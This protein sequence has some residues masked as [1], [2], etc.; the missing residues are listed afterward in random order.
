MQVIQANGIGIR[1][2]QDGTL[3]GAPVLLLHPL[4]LDLRVWDDLVSHLPPDLR[5]IR[6]DLR[7]HGGSDVPEGA[8]GMQSYVHDTAG[9]L[10]AL[11]VQGA[12]VV[13]LGMG[14]LVAQGLAAERPDL[15]RALVLACTAARIGNEAI[16]ANRAEAARNLGMAALADEAITRWLPARFRTTRPEVAALWRERLLQTPPEGHAGACAAIGGTDLL[17]STSRLRLPAM[18]VA[19]AMDAAV[20]ADMVRETA[21]LIPGAEFHVLPGVGHL[22]PVE[23]PEAFAA[24]L[25]P[26]LAKHAP[27]PDLGGAQDPPRIL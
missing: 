8:Q 3:D 11:D 18:A 17:T 26:F 13:G 19:G 23:A 10:D 7:G 1:H 6:C 9:L 15:V 25:D 14:G 21:D 2:V 16:W 20:P 4:G 24:L 22:P 5:V 27:P 12:V